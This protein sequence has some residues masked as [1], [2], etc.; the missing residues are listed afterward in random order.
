MFEIQRCDVHGLTGTTGSSHRPDKCMGWDEGFIVG[1]HYIPRWAL[2]NPV[3]RSGR[4]VM[5]HLSD[6]DLDPGSMVLS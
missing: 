1:A 2:D 4:T 6:I 3:W 5:Y